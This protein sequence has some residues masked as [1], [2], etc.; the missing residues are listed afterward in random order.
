MPLADLQRSIVLDATEAM[1][2]IVLYPPDC[3]PFIIL[4]NVRSPVLPLDLYIIVYCP[5]A[6]LKSLTQRVVSLFVSQ[7]DKN[8]RL[9]LLTC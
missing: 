7:N 4:H 5:G 2:A 1:V 9:G 6:G 3:G 8:A